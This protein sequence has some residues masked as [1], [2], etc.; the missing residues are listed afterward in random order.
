MAVDFSEVI[1][2]IVTSTHP[3]KHE[4]ILKNSKLLQYITV[5]TKSA[6]K[7]SK[8]RGSFA[9]LYAIY[10]LVEDYLRVIESEEYSAYEGAK[11]MNLFQRQRELPF[12]NKLQNH[13]LNSRLNEEFKKYF[14]GS[15]NV[16]KRNL[17]TQ[18]Y[19]IDEEY[20]NVLVDNEK[21]DISRIILNIIDAYIDTKVSALESFIDDLQNLKNLE[22]LEKSDRVTTIVSELLSAESDARFFEII[23]FCILKFKFEE[24]FI[25][26]GESKDSV[27]KVFFSLYKTGR[28]NAN[29]GGIDFV[30]T[31]IGR[32]FQVTETLDFDKYFLDIDKVNKF[33]ITFVVK[34]EESAAQMNI[35]IRQDAIVRYP[36]SETRK[37]YLEAIEEII[38][39]V[40]LIGYFNLIKASNKIDDFLDL[41][42][43]T[44]SIEFHS[45]RN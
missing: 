20:L 23:S 29:D 7:N 10:V 41:L 33:P 28:T 6:N 16:I 11:F 17:E 43:V 31:P 38:T 22:V 5:K 21:V 26:I 30:L 25:W 40:D 37:L 13:A 36:N 15:S 32:Y 1:R 8:A 18:R 19:W 39:I 12:G 2:N 44:S 9:N 34:I 27:K 45:I 3:D 14:P 42:I 4:E 24:E 35:K